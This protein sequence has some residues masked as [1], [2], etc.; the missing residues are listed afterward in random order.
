M[1]KQFV[2]V[3]LIAVTLAACAPQNRAQVQPVAT[4]ATAQ[5]S[6]LLNIAVR[7]EPASLAT[8]VLGQPGGGLATAKALFN[9]WVAQPN[10]QNVMIPVLVE[11]LPALNTAGWQVFA[12]GRMETTYTLKRNLAW[13]DGTPLTPDDF[14]FS[15]G[16]FMNPEFGLSRVAPFYAMEDVVAVDDRTFM[17]RWS[18]PYADAGHISSRNDEFAPLP[19]HLLGRPYAELTSDTFV[20]Q[21]F[22]SRDYVGSGPYRLDRWEP[23]AF[24]EATAFDR[25]VAGRPKIERIKMTFIADPNTAMANL[26]AGEAHAATDNTLGLQ[27]VVVLKREWGSGGIVLASLGSSYRHT[28]FQLRPELA[29][30]RAILDLRIRRALAQGFDK[31]SIAE[32]VAGGEHDIAQAMLADSM[33]YRIS[34]FG[35]AAERGAVKYPYD[36]RRSEQLMN[37]AGFQKGADGY[38]VGPEGRFRTGI[39]TNYSADF[40][41]EIH[42]MAATWRTTGF[43]VEE[44]IIPAAQAQDAQLGASFPSMLTRTTFAG[45][46]TMV[47]FTS[48]G[49][50]RPENRW[51]GVNR[52]AWTN[53]EYDRLV[54]AF[55]STLDREERQQQVTQLMREFTGDLPA[56]PL[57]YLASPFV[58]ATGL[59]GPVD[60][61]A[62]T[63]NYWNIQEWEFR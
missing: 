15:A 22:W 62:D 4:S 36:P 10:D 16:V 52:G 19:R 9:A 8:K 21:S 55:G 59:R 41:E 48:N 32:V 26:L 40:D 14:V 45:A 49:I 37:E 58:Y 24:L 3:V 7:L 27:H 29:T 43:D 34:E 50:P 30:P 47:G 5:P 53:P 63:S 38:F 28:F 18:R 42:I 25:Y 17:I 20:R 1:R 61:P 23:G 13:H 60:V 33:F 11:T 39:A 12:D 2:V 44:S 57:F 31:P 51:T 35:P 56:I 54:S 6:R 46:T